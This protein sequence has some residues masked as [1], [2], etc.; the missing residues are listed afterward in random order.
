M[1]HHKPHDPE[2]HRFYR[3]EICSKRRYISTSY[4]LQ[5]FD[6]SDTLASYRSYKSVQCVNLWKENELTALL[7]L[8]HMYYTALQWQR[9]MRPESLLAWFQSWCI[10]SV[11]TE[12]KYTEIALVNKKKCNYFCWNSQFYAIYAIHQDQKLPFRKWKSRGN[13][14]Q[15][16]P[17]LTLCLHFLN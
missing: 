15:L 7:F 9:P 4:R 5:A 10:R 8:R 3:Q 17:V 14:R 2:D 16:A 13:T 11:N 12:K 1:L 6:V